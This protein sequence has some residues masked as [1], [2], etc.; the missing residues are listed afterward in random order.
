[1][2]MLKKG[3]IKNALLAAVSPRQIL[4]VTIPVGERLN[5]PWAGIEGWVQEGNPF[6]VQRIEPLVLGLVKFGLLAAGIITFACI[7][8]SAVQWIGSGGDKAAV[9]AARERLTQCLV[10]LT[11]VTTALALVMVVQYFL[12]VQVF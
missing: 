3:R 5:Q 1:M 10:G 8:L 12:G 9:M 2:A 4:A 11:I 7:A 6:K